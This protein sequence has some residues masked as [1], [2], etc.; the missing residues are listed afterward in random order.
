MGKPLAAVTAALLVIVVAPLTASAHDVDPC[1][2]PA[3]GG[4]VVPPP[5]LFSDDGVLS[6]S[7]NYFT[8]VDRAGRTLF[9]FVTPDGLQSPT[10]HVKPGDGLN[11]SVTNQVPPPPPGSPTEVVSN[12]S[13]QCGD[14]TMTITSLNVH[15]HGTNTSPACHGDNVVHTIINSGETFQYSL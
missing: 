7:F 9:C 15:Y 13:N 6:L 12:S 11:L 4:L 5:D 8:T 14:A 3:P 10:L 1:P 2:R